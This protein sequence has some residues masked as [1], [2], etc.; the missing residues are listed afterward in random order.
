MRVFSRETTRTSELRG[1]T[2]H[3]SRTS[4]VNR[5][6]NSGG[7]VKISV[8]QVGRLSSG[9]GRGHTARLDANSGETMASTT[10]PEDAQN[11]KKRIDFN[12]GIQKNETPAGLQALSSLPEGLLQ[13]KG[14]ER[15]K[16]HEKQP[17]GPN[18]NDA[19]RTGGG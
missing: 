9:P 15:E 1:R 12:Q 19:G 16:S 17:R 11:K 18:G 7:G 6:R 2:F 13:L 8:A 5:K 3:S 4:R 10:A 14:A